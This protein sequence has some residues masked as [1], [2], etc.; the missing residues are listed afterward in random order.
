MINLEIDKFSRRATW[1]LPIILF[2]PSINYYINILFQNV[3]GNDTDV[4]TA[5]SYSILIVFVGVS[6]YN[7]LKAPKT[8]KILGL[9]LIIYCYYIFAT[10]EN[11]ENMFA[12]DWFDVVYNPIYPLYLQCI[13]TFLI[14]LLLK[15]VDGFLKIA[16]K[17]SVFVIFMAIFVYI[18]LVQSGNDRTIE[19]MT[20]SYN[21]LLPATI[22]AYQGMENGKKKHMVLSLIASVV[23]IVA[24]ARGAAVCVLSMLFLLFLYSMG[25]KLTMGRLLMFAA[26]LVGGIFFLIYFEEIMQWIGTVLHNNN[27][28]SRTIEKIIKGTVGKSSGRDLIRE[29]L[30]YSFKFMPARGYGIYGDRTLVGSY[31][32]NFILEIIIDYGF[33]IGPLVLFSMAV[34]FL[35]I[36][37]NKQRR[38]VLS[39]F[40]ISI[41]GF[42][43]LFF[44]GSYLQDS[45]FWL[46][47]GAMFLC[48]NKENLV[49]R[50][51][52]DSK[53]KR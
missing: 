20:F 13:P 5:I 11:R 29:Y 24:G 7:S 6:Y 41:P 33:V 23:I 16:T 52:G 51:E 28:K 3:M 36:I 21:M 44:S 30:I 48:L 34:A 4:I 49:I 38:E 2:L 18:A 9:I 42:I 10:P 19:Y 1:L 39:L 50:G 43:K 22:C 37:V 15:D 8:R 26:A 40:I 53:L 35:R 45:I 32:H 14:T 47:F 12:G 31:A 25:K 27:I 17:Y 46:F